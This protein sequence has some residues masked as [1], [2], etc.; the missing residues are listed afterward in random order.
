MGKSK[1]QAYNNQQQQRQDVYRSAG[2][3]YNTSRQPSPLEGEMGGVSNEFMNNYRNAAQ[4]NMADY[5]NIMKGFQDYG[6]NANFSYNKV[7]ADRPAE[8][9][10]GYGYLREAMPGYREF[11]NTGGYSAADQQELRAR[12]MAPIRSAYGNTMMEMDRAR[13]LGGNGGAANY[14][15]ASSKAQREMPGQ[16]ADAMTGVNAKLAEDIRTG[17]L[18]G[19]EGMTKVGG[20][21]GGLADSEAGRMLQAQMANQGADLQTQSM[22]DRARQFALGGQSQLY[23][24]T[25]GMASTFGNQALNAYNTR[26]GM[27]QSRNQFGLGALDAQVRTFNPNNDVKPKPWWQ[28]ALGYGAQ[29]GGNIL[30]AYAGTPGGRI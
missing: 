2:D 25:P 19:L 24:T 6:K 17:K 12:G 7:S 3:A 26:A 20:T 23:G 1:N 5:G 4:T 11:A 22:T 10:E 27:E 16:M 30:G 18:A 8:L 13:S 21:M 15:A 28:T 29:I 9:G 14:I